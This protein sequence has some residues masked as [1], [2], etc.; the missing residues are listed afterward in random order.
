MI[1]YLR[2]CA[3]LCR[4]AGCR[5][6]CEL[7]C[8]L[9][10]LYRSPNWWVTRSPLPL[11]VLES[12]LEPGRQPRREDVHRLFLDLLSI[13]LMSPPVTLCFL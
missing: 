7:Q 8:M 3:L 1:S 4:R 2:A 13:H 12:Y 9:V 11:Q 5:A 10:N 6:T